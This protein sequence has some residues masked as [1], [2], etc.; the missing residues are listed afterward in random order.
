MNQAQG[1]TEAPAEAAAV[2]EKLKGWQRAFWG[3][4]GGLAPVLLA[5]AVVEGAIVADFFNEIG[6]PER[7]N[8]AI[9]E[10]VGFV[11]RTGGLI[12]LGAVW[13]LLHKRIGS[14]AHAFE[15]GVLAP[16][17][18]SALINGANIGQ[19]GSA[20]ASAWLGIPFISTAHAQPT[21]T[22]KEPKPSIFKCILDGARGR[23]C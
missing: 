6:D 2:V 14:A 17:M 22:P 10:I 5:L 11:L 3:A 7:K 19:L 12:V 1:V 16:A 18:V 20:D 15:L 8:L 13:A 23:K 4:L 9:G 21:T